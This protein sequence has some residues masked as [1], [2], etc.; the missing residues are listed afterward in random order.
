MVYSIPMNGQDPTK[1]TIE[2]TSAAPAFNLD[3]SDPSWSGAQTLSVSHFLSR[4]S[5]HRPV[6][7]AKLLHDDQTIYVFFHVQDRYVRAVAEKYQDP[8]CRDSCVEF[9]V[10]PRAGKGYFNFEFNCGGTLLLFYIEDPTRSPDPAQPFKKMTPISWDLASRIRV[11]HSMPK[12]IDPEIDTPTTWS[13]Q[14][15]IPR[16]VFEHHV[17][18]LG[19]LADQTWRGNFYKCADKTS[20]PHWATWSPI[21]EVNF[22]LPRCFA[23]IA[24]AR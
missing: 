18:P 1:Y 22:H 6:T 15:A 16:A 17:G 10:E 13:I 12:S 14:Y 9:F 19:S 5:D 2:R 8:V 24:F 21:D 23:P 3:W 4:S 7:R 20:H 11:A